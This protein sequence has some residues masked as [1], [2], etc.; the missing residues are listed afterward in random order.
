MTVRA[1]VQDATFNMRGQLYCGQANATALSSRP[2]V[3]PLGVVPLRSAE[4]NASST[5]GMAKSVYYKFILKPFFCQP[6]WFERE[7]RE[8]SYV[9]YWLEVVTD[10]FA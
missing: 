4:K 1:S 3:S 10:V 5:F 2:E 9:I 8:D 6:K 7:E